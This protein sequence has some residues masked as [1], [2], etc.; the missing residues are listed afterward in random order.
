MRVDDSATILLSISNILTKSGYVA[1]KA[2]NANE[3]LA[4]F[5]AGVMVDLL[6]TGLNMGRIKPFG[7]LF[8]HMYGIGGSTILG[9][10]EVARILDVAAL[11]ELAGRAEE[12]RKPPRIALLAEERE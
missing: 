3:G 8:K 11:T 9:S 10:G 2:V 6:L 1:K 7:S 4:K 12:R 5:R